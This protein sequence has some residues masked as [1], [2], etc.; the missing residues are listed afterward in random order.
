MDIRNTFAQLKKNGLLA[1]CIKDSLIYVKMFK[2]QNAQLIMKL[3]TK[4]FQKNLVISLLNKVKQWEITGP[5][6]LLTF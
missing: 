2:V 1:F 6:V 3:S 5:L 4:I